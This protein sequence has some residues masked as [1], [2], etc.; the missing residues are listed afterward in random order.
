MNRTTLVACVSFL[1]TAASVQGHAGSSVEQF[2]AD[3]P[4]TRVVER[5]GRVRQTYG[6]PISDGASALESA[7]TFRMRHAEVFGAV[8]GELVLLPGGPGGGRWSSATAGSGGVPDPGPFAI[9][10]VVSNTYWRTPLR[11]HLRRRR[12]SEEASV[13]DI[14]F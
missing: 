11:P 6:Q 14:D 2:V 1:L 13:T 12:S 5:A 4:G 7:E 3:H 8:P 9:G 10:P